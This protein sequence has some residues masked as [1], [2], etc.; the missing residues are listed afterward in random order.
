MNEIQQR[1]ESFNQAILAFN[2]PITSSQ[3]NQPVINEEE[4]DEDML[5]PD[6]A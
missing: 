4:F 2:N 1:I 5:L 3:P 6:P